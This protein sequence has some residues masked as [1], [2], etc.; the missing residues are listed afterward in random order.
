MTIAPSRRKTILALALVLLGAAAIRLLRTRYALPYLAFWDEPL[1]VQSGLR[2]LGG[3]GWDPYTFR[4]GSLPIYLSALCSAA[5][6]ILAAPTGAVASLADWVERSPINAGGGT[7][8]FVT[9]APQGWWLTRFVFACM[10]LILVWAVYK[11]ARQLRLS[12][13]SALTASGLVAVCPVHVVAGSLAT[14]DGMGLSFA[15]LALLYS[16]IAAGR[17]PRRT[18]LVVGAC[19]GL[20]VATKFSFLAMSGAS[21]ALLG[22]VATRPP[23]AR[24]QAAAFAGLAALATFLL[25][26]PFA[27]I[28]IDAYLAGIGAELTHY[29]FLGYDAQH[30]R[31]SW[32]AVLRVGR[33]LTLGRPWIDHLLLSIA[34]VGIVFLLVTRWRSHWRELTILIGTGVASL[35]AISQQLV[36]FDRSALPLLPVY[37]VLLAAGVDGILERIGSISGRAAIQLHWGVLA[38]I[39]IPLVATGVSE[40]KEGL[41]AWRF[42]D[43]RTVLSNYLTGLTLPGQV[44]AINQALPLYYGDLRQHR[45]TLSIVDPGPGT[46]LVYQ[47]P[48]QLLRDIV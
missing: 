40:T 20:A 41:A 15:T 9:Q 27:L 38:L 6:Y 21:V 29:G 16:V 44:V 2:I 22:I 30:T 7:L 34:A 12:R 3:G 18:W 13:P 39:W 35:W 46:V 19:T 8:A 26:S 43:S 48:V 17:A 45:L 23:A 37:A 5:A 14:V 25:C 1:V 32:E 47:P 31:L 24:A 33:A 28:S 36:F 10:S 42:S 11:L 4:Y